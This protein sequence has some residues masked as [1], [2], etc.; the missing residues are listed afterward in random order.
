MG[1]DERA[2]DR[3]G[4]LGRRESV[5]P[6]PSSSRSSLDP[7]P[8]CCP[9]WRAVSEPRTS[10][11]G[12]QCVACLAPADQSAR[13]R[14][15]TRRTARVANA[16]GPVDGAC[17]SIRRTDWRRTA[18]RRPRAP[19]AS[20]HRWTD[21][22]A[23][24]VRPRVAAVVSGHRS[25]SGARP[26]GGISAARASRAVSGPR[27]RCNNF[28]NDG[29]TCRLRR[30]SPQPRLGAV[31]VRGVA[32]P[33]AHCSPSGGCRD[34]RPNRSR[35]R[36]GAVPRRAAGGTAR[37]VGMAALPSPGRV[38]APEYRRRPPG[39][40]GEELTPRSP[41]WEP[42]PSPPV[43]TA[44]FVSGWAAP[45]AGSASERSRRRAVRCRSPPQSGAVERPCRRA[46]SQTR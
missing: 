43:V 12:A 18:G 16:V 20:E 28:R 10:P 46:P 6:A 26:N 31:R 1:G 8:A 22:R 32:S 39:C 2:C 3:N 35:R 29:P 17:R 41:D 27:A 19:R 4:I 15:R 45:V 21:Q 5:S 42:E 38:R 14:A 30:G 13:G 44:R 37:G 9:D 23:P 36:R 11:I 24:G 25:G 34:G 7:F 40:P 33:C